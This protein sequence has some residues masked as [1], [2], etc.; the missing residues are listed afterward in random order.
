MVV[1][2]IGMYVPYVAVH[3]SLFERLI[4]MTREKGNIGYLMYLADSAGYLGVCLL[5]FGKS[6]L[7]TGTDFLSFFLPLCWV[8]LAT[9]LVLFAIAI[10]LYRLRFPREAVPKPAS[11]PL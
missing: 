9:T 3:T 7:T 5:M 1:L 11:I 6:T 4:A 10:F 2:G 8:L